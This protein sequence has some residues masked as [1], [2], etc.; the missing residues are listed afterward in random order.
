M[1]VIGLFIFLFLF[2][3]VM[4]TPFLGVGDFSLSFFCCKFGLLQNADLK[5]KVAKLKGN[6]VKLGVAP[7]DVFGGLELVDE[8]VNS[9]TLDGELIL[10]VLAELLLTRLNL[11]H[12]YLLHRFSFLRVLP[13]V[14]F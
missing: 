14:F 2:V 13:F 5:G 9:R 6:R 8:G 4:P 11:Y 3:V 10:D 7:S 1:F 12:S